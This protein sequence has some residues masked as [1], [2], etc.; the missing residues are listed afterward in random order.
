MVDNPNRVAIGAMNPRTGQ[1]Y[2]MDDVTAYTQMENLMPTPFGKEYGGAKRL[3][4]NIPGFGSSY[5]IME[6]NY[7]KTVLPIG[8]SP[9]VNYAQSTL[10][11][12][13]PFNQLPEGVRRLSKFN[14]PAFGSN[15]NQYIAPE[16]LTMDN[17]GAPSVQK[18]SMI[19]NRP[20]SQI[21]NTPTL[22][23]PQRAGTGNYGEFYLP[24]R[25][26][27]YT[28]AVVENSPVTR[29]EIQQANAMGNF[30]TGVDNTKTP[31]FFNKADQ[32]IQNNP[33]LVGQLGT[34]ALTAGSQMNRINKLARPRTLAD[35]RLR[36]NVANPNLVDYSAERNAIDRAAENH[37]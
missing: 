21:G 1:P 2:T 20:I 32:F 24:K 28:D 30:P 12:N 22:P 13:E 37:V 23:M 11:P 26:Q 7:D 9:K 36:E 19:A 31:G 10:T 35:V 4:S 17:V 16:N 3:K 15:T 27:A 6:G 14:L 8:Y 5:G 33:G 29:E 34:A 25:G 18:P